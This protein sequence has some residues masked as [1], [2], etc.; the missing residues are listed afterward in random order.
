MKAQI[1][2]VVSASFFQLRRIRKISRFLTREALTLV[3][4]A[5]VISRLDYANS[6]YLGIPVYQ[7]RRLQ[8]V[9]NQAARLIFHQPKWHHVRP[10]MKSLHWLPVVKRCAFKL[11]CT[12]FEA[13]YGNS[14]AFISS[15]LH[16]CIPSRDLGSSHLSLLVTPS[17]KRK[18]HGGLRFAVLAPQFWNSLP[19]EMRSLTSLAQFRKQLK[20]WLFS[21]AYDD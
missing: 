16:R 21:Q 10:L 13:L 6:L 15:R 17:F 2:S 4:L 19:A 9:Q 11:G 14:P 3:I 20:T 1:S 7:L 5:L 12:I 8:L 18:K